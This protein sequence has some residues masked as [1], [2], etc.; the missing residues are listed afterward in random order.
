MSQTKAEL[1]KGLNINA[2]APATALNIDSSG[3]VGIGTSTATLGGNS[4]RL[5]VVGTK[6]YSELIPRD[7]LAIADNTAT[8]QGVGGS[9][10]FHG[11]YDG[12]S[13]YTAFGG[14]EGQKENGTSGNYAGALVLKSRTFLGNLNEAIR[15]DSSQRVGIGTT[16]PLVPLVVSN[17]G[18]AGIE[19]YHGSGFEGIQAYN[20]STSAYADLLLGGANVRLANATGE[21]ARIDASGRLLVGTSTASKNADRLAGTK[22]ALVGVG[23]VFTSQVI[24]GYTANSAYAAPL[25]D[26]QKSRGSSDG[27]MTIVAAGDYLGGIQFLGS[28]GTNFIRSALILAE[29]DGTPGTNDMPGRLT[30]STTADGASSP[31]ER[32]YLYSNGYVRAPGVYALTTATAADVRVDSAGYLYRSTSSIRYK[33]DVETIQDGYADA[34]LNARPVW[35]RSLSEKD[36][37]DWGYWGFIAE[38][39]EQID[40]RLCTYGEDEEGNQRVESVQYDRFVPHLLNLIKRQGEAIAELQAEVAALRA[41]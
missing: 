8:A 14:I 36:N 27:S 13:N 22:L 6:T 24:T 10:T 32:F 12:S 15:I 39:V 33:K 1:I 21:A 3:R 2:S 16:S 41:Q 38:E 9:I 34:I 20:R 4:F 19:L 40:P 26:F 11:I 23:D 37:P 35:F 29:V 5:A 28:D 25:I 18:A 7:G 31:T 30:F 17:A